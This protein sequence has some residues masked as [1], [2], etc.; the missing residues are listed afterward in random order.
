MQI[1]KTSVWSDNPF[2]RIRMRAIGLIV[3]PPAKKAEVHKIVPPDAPIE[4]FVRRPKKVV[5]DDGPPPE[6]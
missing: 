4:K 6:D 5:H 2:E 3:E 1:A